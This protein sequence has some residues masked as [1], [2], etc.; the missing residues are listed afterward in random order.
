MITVAMA[1]TLSGRFSNWLAGRSE[2]RRKLIVRL[3]ELAF[4]GVAGLV[5]ASIYWTLAAFTS[6]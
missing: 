5:V 3:I 6:R 2:P 1:S 4:V